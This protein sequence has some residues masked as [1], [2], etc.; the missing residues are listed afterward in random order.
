MKLISSGEIA[1]YLGVKKERVMYIKKKFNIYGIPKKE[2]GLNHRELWFTPHQFELI[3]EIS[4]ELDKKKVLKS[5]EVNQDR[6]EIIE[7]GGGC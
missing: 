7:I 6:I 5:K 1:E 2:V 4:K 3:K